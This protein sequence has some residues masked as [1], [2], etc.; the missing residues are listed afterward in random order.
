MD[1]AD[2][3]RYRIR[4]QQLDRSEEPR[5]VTDAAIFDLGVQDTGRDGASWALANRGVPVH[6]PA[7]LN[8]APDIALAWTLRSAPHFY[9]RSELA[10]VMVATSP[11]SEP[12]AVKRVFGAAKPLRR[13]GHHHSGRAG[14]GRIWTSGG[15]VRAAGKG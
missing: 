4:A 12:D 5:A 15:R 2:V 6:S 10:D 1:R 13:G 11:L 8:A 3:I 9:R 7:E 14:R